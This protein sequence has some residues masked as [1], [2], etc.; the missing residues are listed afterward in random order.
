MPTSS[1]GSNRFR[2][3]K[4]L[5]IPC[6][7]VYSGAIPKEHDEAIKASVKGLGTDPESVKWITVDW[8]KLK[9]PLRAEQIAQAI[10]DHLRDVGL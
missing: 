9:S 8:E 5:R 3:Q 1:E 10:M 6:A 4:E 2:C 7:V